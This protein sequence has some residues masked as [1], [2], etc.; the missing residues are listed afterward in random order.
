[1]I[2]SIVARVRRDII[3]FVLLN[4]RDFVVPGVQMG[5]TGVGF[6]FEFCS[7]SSATVSFDDRVTFIA[8]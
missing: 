7:Q 5:E 4:D 8:C 3:Y 6:M 2:G 1:M